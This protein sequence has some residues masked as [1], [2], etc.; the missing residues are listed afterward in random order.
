MLCWIWQKTGWN[1]VGG[2]K[3]AN[4]LYPE[5]NLTSTMRNH[6]RPMTSSQNVDVL[7]H[8]V[9]ENENSTQG[10]I[11]NCKSSNSFIRVWG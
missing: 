2:G 5:D 6:A 10:N 1:M 7:Q 3:K 4:A 8:N 11:L 9:K